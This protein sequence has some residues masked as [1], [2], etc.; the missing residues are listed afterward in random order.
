MNKT[1]KCRFAFF[2]VLTLTLFFTVSTLLAQVN[3]GAGVP[4]TVLPKDLQGLD[5]KDQFLPSTMKKV[6]VIHALRGHVVVTHRA[7]RAP[8]FGREGDIIY[9]NDSLN[10]LADSRCRIKLFD[11]DVITMGADTQFAVEEYQDQRKQRRKSSFFSMFKGKAM[12]YAMRLFRYK[13]SRFRLKTPTVTVGV[14]GT[15][16]GADIIWEEDRRAKAGIRV[17]DSSS[18]VGAYLAAAQPGGKTRETFYCVDGELDVAGTGVGANNKW[19][20]GQVMAFTP[21]EFRQFESVTVV[22]T[23][24][25]NALK[26]EDKKEKVASIESAVVADT[27]AESTAEMLSNIT[28]T[29]ADQT[30]RENTESVIKEHPQAPVYNHGY[31][32]AMLT[33]AG[34]CCPGL[35]D[36]FQSGRQAFTQSRGIAESIVDE[37]PPEDR[38]FLDVDTIGGTGAFDEVEIS[39][40]PHL[41][42]ITVNPIFFKAL[43]YLDYGYWKISQQ[44]FGTDNFRLVDLAWWTRMQ[45]TPNEAMQGFS[46]S[47]PYSGEAHGTYYQDSPVN[48]QPLLMHGT[49]NGNV[50]FDNGTVNNFNL[51]VETPD[52]SHSVSIT[53]VNGI[54]LPG[55]TQSQFEI[56]KGSAPNPQWKLDGQTASYGEIDG[57]LAGPEGEE[58][59]G[60]WAIKK[61]GPPYNKAATGIFAG[62]KEQ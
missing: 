46:G 21:S 13:E 34:G 26:A 24:T 57:T 19:Q 12:F 35:E 22:K 48:F 58:M 36:V 16:F 41:I 43:N 61:L 33:R 4:P 23:E 45:I 1:R 6:G 8:Y 52:Q 11:D 27:G 3:R 40:V 9:E 55:S 59:G 30:Q 17:A 50:N 44:Q 47:V 42:N 38:L 54:F 37:P 2:L 56:S 51:N 7:T 62:S 14:R 18:D 25:E 53:G 10:T 20:D 5:I 49:F 39:G 15:K 32:S 31:F 29:T 28:D 60:T